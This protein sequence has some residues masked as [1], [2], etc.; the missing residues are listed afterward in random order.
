MV[1]E[2]VIVSYRIAYTKEV[3]VSIPKITDKR[4]ASRLI[5]KKAVW[6]NCIGKVSGVHGRSGAVKIKF[7]RALP[8][9][10]LGK[11]VKIFD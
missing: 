10:S 3:I 5:G 2:G 4:Q 11:T 9:A 7:R 8:P 1:L 6:Q